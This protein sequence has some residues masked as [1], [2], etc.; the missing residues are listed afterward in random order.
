M[1]RIPAIPKLSRLVVFLKNRDGT[2]TGTTTPGVSC[3]SCC[4]SCCGS[5][6]GICSF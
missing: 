6:S 2:G 1:N 4:G 5:C 3:L